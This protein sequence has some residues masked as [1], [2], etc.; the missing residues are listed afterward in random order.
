MRALDWAVLITAL[1]SVVIYGIWKSRNIKDSENFLVGKRDLPWWTIGLS[2]MATQASAITFLSTPGQSFNDGMQF[3]QFYFG[4]PIAMILLSVFVLPIYYKLRVTTAYEYLEQR[5]D[6][7]MRTLTASL[8]LIQ[9]G[10]AAAISIYAPSI[11]LSVVFGWNLA[12]VNFIMAV[13]VVIYT[14]SGGS[15]AVSHTQELQMTIML[16]GLIMAFFLILNSLPEGVGVTEAW[17]IAGLSGKTQVTDWGIR[18]DDSG[19]RY[20]DWN[21][22]YNL[23]SG[24]L[25]STFL[26]LSYFGTD[27]SQVG[28]YLSGK[29]LKESRFGLLFNGVIKIPM[30][31][32]VLAVGV[33]VYVFFQFQRPPLYFNQAN[34]AKIAET[35]QNVAFTQLEARADSVFLLKKNALETYAIAL[36]NGDQVTQQSAGNDVQQLEKEYIGLRKKSESIAKEALGKDD[37]KDKD[38]VFINYI[39]GHMPMGLVGLMLAMIFCASW[40]TTASELSALTATSV[41]DIYRRHFVKGRDDAFY[42]RASK[43][44]TVLWG[45]FIVVFASYADLFDNLIQAVNMVGSIFYGTILGIFFTAFFLKKV[46]GSA[47][48]WAA[49][50]TQIIVASLFFGWSKDPYLWYNPLGCGL[51]MLLSLLFQMLFK[52]DRFVPTE[53]ETK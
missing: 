34:R 32:L 12:F 36:K 14:T 23:W 2:I 41:S 4:M 42:F 18:T 30:Q 7:R 6:V 27:Q 13:F 26:F 33:M 46:Q 44:A 19:H 20:F 25:G 28:R 47:V 50:V 35:S 9:R 45:A 17:N 53:A 40:S 38:Y 8:F 11:I 24:L 22:R 1:A 29:S 16:G 39:L 43:I 15:T 52:N 37:V 51:V 3:V 48:F 5:F 10:I 21:D 31:F 49:V